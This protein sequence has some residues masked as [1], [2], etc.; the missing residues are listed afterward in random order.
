MTD[1]IDGQPDCPELFL[2]RCDRRLSRR[3]GRVPT[4]VLHFGD[5]NTPPR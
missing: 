2:Q 1:T 3:V 5:R 4:I